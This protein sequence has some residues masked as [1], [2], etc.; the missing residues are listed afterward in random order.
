[1]T[2]VICAWLRW[3]VD[4]LWL[5]QACWT[6]RNPSRHLLLRPLGPWS[7]IDPGALSLQLRQKIFV[8]GAS[9]CRASE[10]W[11][12]PELSRF[13]AWNAPDPD[14]DHPGF[15]VFSCIFFIVIIIC[16]YSL[17]PGCG[18]SC[19]KCPSWNVWEFTSALWGLM[20][21]CTRRARQVFCWSQDVN[22]F[23]GHVVATRIFR[24][25]EIHEFSLISDP[26][27]WF[28]TCLTVHP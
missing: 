12:M 4:H 21:E 9:R 6:A 10:S 20:L 3:R 23:G 1:M 11:E 24:C 8:C 16:F 27:W 25:S 5:S 2:I 22:A 18:D 28:Q 14:L 19:S 7:P 17:S 15:T 26:D 13:R